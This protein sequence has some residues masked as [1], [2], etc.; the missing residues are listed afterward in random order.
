MGIFAFKFVAIA[1]ILVTAWAG[2]LLSMRVH[3]SSRRD[4]L[5][6]LGNALAGGIFLGVAL[7]HMLPDATSIFHAL[8]PQKKFPLAFLLASV[9]FMLMLFLEEIL[10]VDLRRRLPTATNKPL[11]PYVMALVLAIHSLLAGLA[12]GMAGTFWGSLAIFIAI[13]AHKGSAAFALG[14]SL[15]QGGVSRRQIIRTLL[16]FALATPL[17]IIFGSLFTHLSAG[18]TGYFFEAV[19][20]ALA[21]GT[22]LYISVLDIIKE[23]F[24]DRRWRWAKFSLVTVGLILMAMLALW[25]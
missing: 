14:I 17:G 4:L 25:L 8:T 7:F 20:D 23:A 3:V 24:F 2:G 11:Y 9:G 5:F 15:H 10:L 18:D 22:F 19:F 1:V 12:L 21:A 16:L 13:I 6:S